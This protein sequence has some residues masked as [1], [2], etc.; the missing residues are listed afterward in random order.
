M[1]CH[2]GQGVR[3]GVPPTVAAATAAAHDGGGG[4]DGAAARDDARSAG[5]INEAGAGHDT[6][7][8]GVWMLSTL[9]VLQ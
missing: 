6:M 5:S 9:L 1:V 2:C 8:M 3:V 7:C 4:D